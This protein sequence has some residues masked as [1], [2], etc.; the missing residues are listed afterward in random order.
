MKIGII[1][2][3]LTGQTLAVARKLESELIKAGHAVTLEQL[4][5]AAPFRLTAKTAELKSKP[6]MDAYRAIVLASPV[7]GGRMAVPMKSFLEQVPS[8]KGKK[9]ACLVTQFL[10]HQLGGD[11]TIRMMKEECRSKGA[12]V[13]GTGIVSWLSISRKRQTSLVVNQL[14]ALFQEG[15]LI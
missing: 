12:D 13:V 2:F 6:I 5:T 14:S 1:V 3:S 10:P 4:E 15:R 8:L 7:H 9:V 11:Q